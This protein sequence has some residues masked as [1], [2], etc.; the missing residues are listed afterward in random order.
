MKKVI[1]TTS[2]LC[3]AFMLKAQVE[4]IELNGTK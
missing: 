4:K 1:V 2:L 3:F